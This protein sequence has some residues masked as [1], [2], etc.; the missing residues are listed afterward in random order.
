MGHQSYVLLCSKITSFQ[1]SEG[2]FPEKSRF[3]S[4]VKISK[5]GFN[6]KWWAYRVYRRQKKLSWLS[7]FI[8]SL[9]CLKACAH[10]ARPLKKLKKRIMFCFASALSLTESEK[11]VYILQILPFK[12][13]C[14]VTTSCRI[15]TSI[16]PSFIKS[17]RL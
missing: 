4:E 3:F 9:W 16:P 14:L 15:L 7:S 8:F 11:I 12:F 6:K 10:S 2:N 17:L 5:N 13:K 1:P